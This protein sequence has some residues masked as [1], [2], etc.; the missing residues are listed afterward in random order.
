MVLCPTGH[1]GWQHLWFTIL[2]SHQARPR[3]AG[4][5]R[6]C[7]SS[8][9]RLRLGVSQ[10]I[11]AFTSLSTRWV[12]RSHYCVHNAFTRGC[13]RPIAAFTA[14][15]TP[16]VPPGHRCVHSALSSMDV[17]GPSLRLPRFR[18][19][20]FH[21]RWQHLWSLVRHAIGG[22]GAMRYLPQGSASRGWTRKSVA[23]PPSPP[24]TWR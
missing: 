18:L 14:L 23:Q 1:P 4:R 8:Q 13:Y 3:L 16:W 20:G 24:A 2:G 17:T 10:G 19:N 7:Y 21:W 15:S 5:E 22:S 6:L 11:A 9:V 12:S